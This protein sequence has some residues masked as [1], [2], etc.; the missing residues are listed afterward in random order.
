[1]LR[2]RVVDPKV[3][4]DHPLRWPAS[5]AIAKGSEI[6]FDAGNASATVI[7]GTHYVSF[8][9][10]AAPDTSVLVTDV[11]APTAKV[12]PLSPAEAKR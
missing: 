3:I 9:S 10:G 1:V 8:Y 12:S 11:P 2:R 7:N 4:F 6:T 5:E